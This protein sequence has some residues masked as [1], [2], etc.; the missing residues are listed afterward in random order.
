MNSS[1][2]AKSLLVAAAF[3]ATAAHADVDYITGTVVEVRPT[4]TQQK[5]QVPNAVCVQESVPVYGNVDKTGSLIG[6]A[7]IGGIIG[8]QIDHNGAAGAILGGMIG[9]AKA[10]NE[11]PIIGYQR[12]E[13]CY[14]EIAYEIRKVFVSNTVVVKIEGT[15]MEFYSKRSYKVGEQATIKINRS[16]Q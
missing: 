13:N 9:N 3:T 15:V 2:I 5:V 11:R 16:L 10:D 4:Y 8:N 12:V 6:G 7:I 14:N 1:S